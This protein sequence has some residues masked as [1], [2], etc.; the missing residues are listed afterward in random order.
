VTAHL[1]AC[2]KKPF[3]HYPGRR[4]CLDCST[5][6]ARK[7]DAELDCHEYMRPW[8]IGKRLREGFILLAATGREPYA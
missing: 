8:R 4:F 2:C 3:V 6:L 7:P 1:C 5:N